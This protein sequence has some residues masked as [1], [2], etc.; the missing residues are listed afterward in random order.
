MTGAD[1]GMS[2][3]DLIVG[4]DIPVSAHRET[5][6]EFLLFYLH[7]GLLADHFYAVIDSGPLGVKFQVVPP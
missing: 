2:R 3:K 7:E 5:T 6:P 4:V 1:V